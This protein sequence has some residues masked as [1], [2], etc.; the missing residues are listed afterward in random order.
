MHVD[1]LTAS[2]DRIVEE[3]TS[4]EIGFAY[5]LLNSVCHARCRGGQI[6]YIAATSRTYVTV[7]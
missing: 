2:K 1:L 6:G 3:R 7:M 5:V 4:Y